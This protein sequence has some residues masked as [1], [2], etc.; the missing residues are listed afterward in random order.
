M[1]RF[2]DERKFTGVYPG[3]G[4]NIKKKV[5]GKGKDDPGTWAILMD[6]LG[7]DFGRSIE[8]VLIWMAR[9]VRSLLQRTKRL[10]KRVGVL[11]RKKTRS[12]LTVAPFVF[13]MMT[14]ALCMTLDYHN[15]SWGPELISGR[16]NYTGLIKH[17]KLPEDMC[18]DGV[19]VEKQCPSVHKSEHLV[20]IDCGVIHSKVKRF[21]LSY[22]RCDLKERAKRNTVEKAG[23]RDNM[24]QTV[25][26]FET[27]AFLWLK[28]HTFSAMIFIVVVGVAMKWPT[29]I[30][31]VLLLCCWGAVMGNHEEAFLT[32]DGRAQTLVKARLYPNEA[33]T[34]MTESGLLELKTGNFVISDGK[35]VKTLLHQCAVN[36]SFSVDCCPMGCD[37]DMSKINGK[38]RI[39]ERATIQRGWGSGCLEFGT[40]SVAT[41]VEVDCKEETK[42]MSTSGQDILVEIQGV[43]HSETAK[44]SVM[45]DSTKTLSFGETG[46]VTISCALGLGS[47]LNMYLLS[48]GQRRGLFEKGMIDVWAGMYEI[49]KEKHGLGAVIVWG[50]TKTNE[51][52]VK[53]VL[54]PQLDWALG[55]D[56]QNGI[57]EGAYLACEVVVD[58]LLVDT[59]KK[60]GKVANVTFAQTSVWRQ[61][62]ALVAL[63]EKT[64]EDCV[65]DIKCNGCFLPTNLLFFSKGSVNSTLGLDCVDVEGSLVIEGGKYPVVCKKSIAYSA[66]RTIEV[67]SK[68]YSTYGMTGVK[69]TMFDFLGAM[70]FKLK[71][72]E[73]FAILALG[74]SFIDKRILMVIVTIGTLYY[75]RADVGCGIDTQRKT[76]SCGTGI[77]VWRSLFSWPSADETVEIEN[78]GLFDGYIKAQFVN[79]T[80]VC[81][82]CEDVLQCAAARSA[83]ESFVY[84]NS[85]VYVNMTLSRERYFPNIEKQIV[86][87]KIGDVDTQLAV[88]EESG[89]VE[90]KNL[91]LLPKPM[92]AFQGAAENVTDRVLRVISSGADRGGICQ[93]S[94]A[95]QYE[96][97]SFKRRFIGSSISV[98]IAETID[99][100]CPTY[101]TGMAVKGNKTVYTDG[102]FWMASEFNGTVYSIN[103]LHLQQSHKCVWPPRYV[104]DPIKLEDTRLFV[105]PVWGAP[106]SAAN[107]IPG[108]KTQTDFPWM[109]YP[110]ELR[111]GVVPGTT[112]EPT[113]ECS[114]RGSATK[115]DPLAFPKWCCKN[116][117]GVKILHF[118]IDDSYYYPMEIRVLP[119]KVTES[120]IGQVQKS[121]LEEDLR[122]AS[123]GTFT[124]SF[125]GASRLQDFR[126]GPQDELGRLVTLTLMIMVLTARTRNKWTMRAL[127]IWFC[128]AIIGLPSVSSYRAWCW[129]FVS[130]AAAGHSG[131]TQWMCHLW[132]A[133]QT[134]T[135]HIWML[136]FMWRRRLMAS[137]EHKM[138]VLLLQWMYAML[139]PSL[140]KAHMLLDLLGLG[141]V[142][143]GAFRMG[144]QL[145]L[146]DVLVCLLALAPSWQ[147]VIGLMLTSFV[148]KH[149]IS[150]VRSHG[151]DR[152]GWKSGL[153]ST[154]MKQNMLKE[155]TCWLSQVWHLLITQAHS[156][157]TK[158]YSVASCCFYNH[159]FSC[160]KLGYALIKAGLLGVCSFIVTGLCEHGK[161]RA[162]QSY[163]AGLSVVVSLILIWMFERAG[164]PQLAVATLIVGALV[165]IF[166]EIAGEQKLE[167][168]FIPEG[169]CPMIEAQTFEFD[170]D[171]EG[172]RG[173]DGVQIYGHTD[174]GGVPQSTVFLVG[175]CGLIIVNWQIGISLFIWYFISGCNFVVPQI[176]SRMLRWNL[177]SDNFLHSDVLARDREVTLES[178]FGYL[179]QGAYYVCRTT[180]M[181]SYIIGSG[182]AKNNVFHTLYH[183]THGDP[184]TWR[185]RTVVAGGG[186]SIRDTVSYG[187]GWNLEFKVSP[188][189]TVKA[190]L[191]DGT[192]R[193]NAYTNRTITVDGET[194][195][196]IPEDFGN[197]SSGSPVYDA[198]GDVVGLYGFGFYH[199]G[200]YYSLVSADETIANNEV[201][202]YTNVMREFIDWHPGRG[203]TRKVIVEEARR[204]VEEGKK[205]LILAPTR[206]VKREVMKG[207][208]DS[209]INA[210]VGES[211][212]MTHNAITVACHATFTQNVLG[213]GMG[214]F[215]YQ[216]I[217]MDECHFLDPMSI[218]ARG[219]MEKLHERTVRLVYMSAT[220]PGQ[221]GNG[222]S[223]FEIM[224]RAVVFPRT[225]T[226][227]FVQQHGGDRTVVF[228]P[229]K[230]E[231]DRLRNATPNSVSIHR[232]TFEV[233]KELVPANTKVI[234][235]T[236]IS[237]MGANFDA[238]TVIDSQVSIKPVA[239]DDCNVGLKLVGAPMSSRI[240]RR[241]RIG[242]RGPGFYVF[243]VKSVEASTGEDWICWVEAQMLLDQLEC[244]A[245][246]EEGSF[247]QTP[248][249]FLLPEDGKRKFLEF[250]DYDGLTV[251]LAWHFANQWRYMDTVLFGGPEPT[252][253][254]LST[255]HGNRVYRPKFTDARFE[256]ES[257]QVRTMTLTKLMKCRSVGWYGLMK[258][259]N[260]LFTSGTIRVRAM[261]TVEDLYLLTRAGD[262]G[263]PDM[264]IDR[265]VT[266]LVCVAIGGLLVLSVVTLVCLCSLCVRRTKSTNPQVITGSQGGN[267]TPLVEMI[268]AGMGYFMGIPYIFVFIFTVTI[269]LIR[270]VGGN[271][272]V[273]GLEI[274]AFSRFLVAGA[275]FISFL[276]VWEK[277]LTPVIRRDLS[278]L[279]SQLTGGSL[280]TND[281]PMWVIKTWNHEFL[282]VAYVVVLA[283][284]QI[285]MGILENKFMGAYISEAGRAHVVG[286][287]KTSN[288]PWY[289][290]VPLMPAV[291][292]GTTHVAKVLG[293]VAGSAI[294]CLF[295]FE[296]KFKLTEKLTLN[297]AAEKQKKEVDPIVQRQQADTRK[298]VFSGCMCACAVLWA[299]LMQDIMSILTAISVGM[300]MYFTFVSP[301]SPLLQDFE[302]GVILLLFGILRMEQVSLYAFCLV[303][304]VGFWRMTKSMTQLRAL[305]KTDTGGIGYKWK[306]LLNS[307][308]EAQFIS[309]K[310]RGVNETERGD[311]VSRGGLK[312]DEI[313]TK[314]GWEPRGRVVDLG[315]GRGGWSQRLVADHRVTNVK[316]F[317]LGGAEREN[318]CAFT[319]T[320]YN[321]A[322]L[323]PAVDVYTMEPFMVNTIVCDV[324]ESD[325][326]P[327]VERSRTLKVLEL[328][329]RWLK[330][331][332]NAAF[333][334]KVLAPYHLDVLRKL[335]SLQH[336]YK[337]RLVRLTYSRNS[338]AEMYYIS[339]ARQNMIGAVYSTLLVLVR[340][341]TREDPIIQMD[342]PVLQIGSR[343]NP[344]AKIKDMDF[345]D[346][347][348][349]INRLKDENSR[350]WFHDTEHPYG[351]F[352]YVG[353]F[354]TDARSG[355]GQTVNPMIRRVM[356]PWEELKKVTSFM[357]TDV[358]TFAQQKVLREKVDTLVPEPP[359]NVRRVNRLIMNHFVKMFKERGLKPRVLGS[360]E[361]AANVQSFASVGAWSNEIPWNNVREALADSTFWD[362]VDRERA[363]HLSGDCEMCIYNT[364]GKKEKK[365]TIAGMAKGSRTIWYMWLGCRFLEYEALG[366]LNEDH[367]VSR[368]NFPCGVGGVG[369]N[370]F[371]YYLQE[372]AKRGKYLVADDVAGWD[373]RV[374]QS[375]L[376]D[377]EF[378]VLSMTT[379][380]Y[381][382][383]LIQGMYRFA[384]KKIVALFPR[385]H[386]K[387]GSGTVMDVVVRSDQRG[388]G[389]VTTYSMNTITNGKTQ[390]GRMLE[391]EGLL[392]APDHVIIRWL[393]LNCENV[394]SAMVVAG[395]D[396]VVA[397]NNFR[398]ISS[399]QYIT[400][401]GKLRKDIGVDVPSRFS[402][403]WEEVEFC[404]HHFHQLTLKDG[405]SLVVPC[406][407][408]NEVIGRSRI[409][410][411]G[412]VS[413]EDS[414]CL[415]KAYAQ[416]WALYFFHRRDLR[417]GFAA[418]CASVPKNWYPTG[419][420]SWSVHQKHEWMTT[421]DMLEVWNKVW[422][423]D[424]R[425]IDD[426]T[427]VQA[428]NDIPY[429]HK[430]QDIKCGSI[431]GSNS[432][433]SWAKDLPGL[434]DRTRKMFM[435]QH[436]QAEFRDEL[437]IMS[438]FSGSSLDLFK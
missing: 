236:D 391:A 404:S 412:V 235:T 329:E 241:G 166:I 245:M 15:G 342:P 346:V 233:E 396:V 310:S 267:A 145:V 276:V 76:L 296:H 384:Y 415:A 148:M 363:L 140:G 272:A 252:E 74:L 357:M 367:W 431:I 113:K 190:C 333:V 319:T 149:C 70:S 307:L 273:R 89:K 278:T 49:G 42:V 385:D 86:K 68:R 304:R 182:Y 77:F 370:Y 336:A 20:G 270:I 377:E 199:Q 364:M 84:A 371:G 308:N 38:N 301:T 21:T 254:K 126:L 204:A 380:P 212:S 137:L 108:Y 114:G 341:F 147:I 193:F 405:R 172:C 11:E 119:T 361:Y 205:L 300:H 354:V 418:I 165:W 156:F 197:G 100:S 232:G 153:R 24:R 234:Y 375:D 325:S 237:E 407:D 23:I 180:S 161:L 120:V 151:L 250:L 320:G 201:Q 81:I 170:E 36:G 10:E 103:E 118:R 167:L 189:Y 9:A 432:R 206:V 6:L 129:L 283:C 438:R 437:S 238:D 97:S 64:T 290:T 1:K 434:V 425:W 293:G 338:T 352:A 216:T 66:W 110:I 268:G 257:Q 116:C 386:P 18:S 226:V 154:L 228:L 246:P 125:A 427:Y 55:I 177:R 35:Y 359:E 40:G 350:T 142:A 382:R 47:I 128:F 284:N 299:F 187:G 2:S 416:M 324:G 334:C 312:M 4:G 122:K 318:P 135:G 41:C 78:Y 417:M 92:W 95:F 130:Q 111:F 247:F 322:T 295:W 164:A 353:S 217:I 32:L 339:G 202:E 348:T 143:L 17:F 297:V 208:K 413:L 124:S 162:Q 159:D 256:S 316:G 215:R 72:I 287:F 285:L 141:I 249:T 79:N 326:K 393:L 225:M 426:K 25:V 58:K 31:A 224:D 376:D 277:E 173:P 349:R 198:G 33:T 29:W 401:A 282:I 98:R 39:C 134:T 90:E 430:G 46:Y 14:M 379:D 112:V 93:R 107:H 83:A 263:I 337:G 99:R 327:E 157:P 335:E 60:C 266:T 53:S 67:V 331:N 262:D 305:D 314:H 355:G 269:V 91:G 253:L 347:Q 261:E 211:L 82:I 410:K 420:T 389:Q 298:Q 317:T 281:P 183:V 397:T 275:S 54:E 340:R 138:S 131:Y 435:R 403:N 421:E 255:P 50:S 192:V 101:L 16:D 62:R 200:K 210:R 71:W 185:G 231:C 311:Y 12:R 221:T 394:L 179:P 214:R 45:P 5:K 37:I 362:M 419:R 188:V 289:A 259:I 94:V 244:R 121:D 59:K 388:S 280:P 309:Y 69:N 313:I 239:I 34:I 343:L 243:P 136:A 395:D 321:L 271:S 102:S 88:M 169:T 104:A 171:L 398:F 323:K 330:V 390:I 73:I 294:L 368:D 106:M 424:N 203:K 194:V 240:Q 229:T 117:E 248:G 13:M 30:V 409:Q 279:F 8:A 351:S 383:K 105:P 175:M 423:A 213:A 399:L 85:D 302:L 292:W 369:V 158:C 220:P 186:S 3:G 52:L 381:H 230:Q 48:D 303:V 160:V 195:P 27:A 344:D 22:V 429:L 223:N 258:W 315:C 265:L 411:G 152:S 178:T 365:P 56:A 63:V 345:N 75:V 251:W 174:T 19:R 366:F 196:V 414:A 428:W 436:P 144:Q 360:Q 274:T 306:R 155:V 181:S 176:L 96:F 378:F 150:F 408:E 291:I 209:G 433:A 146:R 422:I 373:T 264:K 80:K 132:F 123:E 356:W 219:I 372:I 168:K 242:R 43:F 288:L 26:E 358:S 260:N 133:I 163:L 402:S 127:G 7:R 328:L 222:G 218:A 115:V 57:N 51:I 28:N 406:R 139:A 65:L 109:K 387:Y 400:Q 227:D 184:I 87:V 286:G 191:P 392:D 44:V 61:G 207:I 374:T 332:P